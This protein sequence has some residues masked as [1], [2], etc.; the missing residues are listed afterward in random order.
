MADTTLTIGGGIA[1]KFS[2][3]GYKPVPD[4][5]LYIEDEEKSKDNFLYK[6]WC[7]ETFDNGTYIY[8]AYKNIAFNIEYT[9]E[10]NKTDF[11]QT[12][13]ETIRLKKGDCEDAVF[14]FFSQLPPNQRNAEITW[15]W[16][17]DKRDEVG[18]AHVWYQLIDKAGKQYIVEGFS[19]DWNGIIPVDIVEE[20]ESRRPM[21]T[22]AHP[23]VSR[24]AGSLPKTNDSQIM[25]SLVDLLA[26]TNFSNHDSGNQPFSQGMDTL[27][28]P[29][30]TKEI[31]NILNK[32]HELFSRYERQ[33]EES[34]MQAAYKGN[35]KK[36]YPERNLMCKR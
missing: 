34:N 3:L 36:S 30:T 8:E 13:L 18:K 26:A 22:I 28:L 4:T 12:P 5:Y 7:E 19:K 2:N 1:D 10:P 17:I 16:V 31:S 14:H 27:L 9:P 15:G 11:W 29:N 33:R 35:T 24:L 20:T 23:A 6:E 21:L 25:Q 32:L